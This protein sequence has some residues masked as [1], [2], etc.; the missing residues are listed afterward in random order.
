VFGPS[1]CIHLDYDSHPLM[2]SAILF[3][4]DAVSH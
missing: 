3:P 2:K 1:L 4:F